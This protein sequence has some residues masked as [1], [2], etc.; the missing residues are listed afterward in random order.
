MEPQLPSTE[1]PVEAARP[2]THGPTRTYER[3]ELR[4]LWDATLC[5]HVGNCLRALPEV[6]DTNARP[7]VNVSGATADRVAEAIRTCPSG[8]LRYVPNG[9]FPPEQ[10]DTPTSI[11]PQPGGPL[12]VRGDLEMTVRPDAAPFDSPRV[13]LCRCGG[14]SNRPFCDNSHRLRRRETPTTKET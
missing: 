9:A 13:A 8:A 7:W 12:F 4:V 10:P 2:G 3:P 1:S 14:S 5:V 11:E 6:F